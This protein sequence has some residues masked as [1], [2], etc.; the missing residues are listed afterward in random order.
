MTTSK[1]ERA[2]TMTHL[3][4]KLIFGQLHQW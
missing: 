2:I 3:T 1:G 4:K